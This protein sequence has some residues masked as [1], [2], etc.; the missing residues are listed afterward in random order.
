MRTSNISKVL[1]PQ[2]SRLHFLFSTPESITCEVVGAPKRYGIH[3]CVSN[4]RLLGLGSVAVDREGL[5][6]SSPAAV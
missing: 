3:Y 1:S 5:S 6:P 4:G 2:A